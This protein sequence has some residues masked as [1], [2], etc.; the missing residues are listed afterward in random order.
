[1]TRARIQTRELVHKVREVICRLGV[2][3]V[4]HVAVHRDPLLIYMYAICVCVSVSPLAH[5]KDSQTLVCAQTH[6]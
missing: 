4:P 6:L 3:C 1:M 5:D 2:L